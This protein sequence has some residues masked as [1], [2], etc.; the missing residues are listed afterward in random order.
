[1]E[2][3][4]LDHYEQGGA[5]LRKAI[6]GL[7]R[8]QLLAHPVPGTWSIQQN[9]VHLMD[10]DLIW[11]ARMK[12]IIAEDNPLLIGYDQSRFAAGLHYEGQ[13]AEDVVTVFDLNRRLFAG[14]LRKLP[15]EAFERTGIHNEAGKISLAFCVQS[16]ASHVDHHA[17][18]ILRK[19]AMLENR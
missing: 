17:G 18:F 14:V 1:M 19:R 3:R 13:A 6:A 4:V 11:T 10:A 16:M 12:R 7:D 9:V 8:G 2:Q 5:I 15:A